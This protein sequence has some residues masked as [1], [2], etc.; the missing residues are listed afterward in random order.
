MVIGCFYGIQYM[1][2]GSVIGCRLCVHSH[3]NRS[4]HSPDAP[5]YIEAPS[6]IRVQN[7]IHVC[8]CLEEGLVLV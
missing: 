8:V 2:L 5:S 3:N 6:F 7:V 1:L 4:G